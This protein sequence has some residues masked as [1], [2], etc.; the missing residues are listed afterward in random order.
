L[1]VLHTLRSFEYDK[2]L[3]LYDFHQAHCRKDICRKE[4]FG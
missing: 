3:D 1:L 4:A 2:L